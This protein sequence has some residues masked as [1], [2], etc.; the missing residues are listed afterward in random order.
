MLFI[1][2][3]KIDF[4]T[5]LSE[6]K[7]MNVGVPST[8]SWDICRNIF[9]YFSLA[10]VGACMNRSDKSVTSTLPLDLV[11]RDTSYL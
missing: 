11:T 4:L 6:I 2:E 1:T 10:G 7:T 5:L 8:I 9:F 3:L